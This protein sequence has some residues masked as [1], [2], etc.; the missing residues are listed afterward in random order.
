[1]STLDEINVAEFNL[2]KKYE[3]EDCKESGAN[4]SSEEKNKILGGMAVDIAKN[5]D[6]ELSMLNKY[7][8]EINKLIKIIGYQDNWGFKWLKIYIFI[9][10]TFFNTNLC[11]VNREFKN[12]KL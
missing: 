10:S 3:I 1:M 8:M 2:D 4:L 12:M 5:F 11:V 9:L 7:E 6:N